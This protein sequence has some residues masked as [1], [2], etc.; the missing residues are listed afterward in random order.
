MKSDKKKMLSATFMTE[1]GPITLEEDEQGLAGITLPAPAR[2]QPEPKEEDLR[3]SKV[4][5]HAARQIT[6]YLEGR[7]NSF[8]LPL[9]II[10]T[11]FQKKVWKIIAGIPYGRTLSYGDIAR[12][13]GGTGKARA[14]GGAAHANPLPLIIPCHRVIGSDGSLT[15]FGA[16]LGLKEK[17][18]DLEK[19]NS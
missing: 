4:M 6:Q 7:R 1:F 2:R 13:L 5:R 3:K 14:V 16:G 10:G 9:H 18:L 11:D 12:K 19:R 17:L 8:D 15:G